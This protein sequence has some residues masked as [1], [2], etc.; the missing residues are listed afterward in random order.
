[1]AD[2]FKIETP[3]GMVFTTAGKDGKTVARLEWN[4]DFSSNRSGQFNQSQKFV[5]SE[6]LRLCSPYVPFQTGML[7]KSGTLGTDI[8]S[9]E[10]NYIAPY[11][12]A[13]YYKTS[14]SRSYDPQRGAKWFERMKIDHKDE[15][16]RG[17]KARMGG[18]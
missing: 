13:Q 15:I 8:G 18:K 16:L 4:R 6:V 11:A 10:V 1:M 3:K 2:G 12:A 9:G 14:T 5:D 7:D 17:A